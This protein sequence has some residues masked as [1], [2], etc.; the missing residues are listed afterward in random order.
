MIATGSDACTT[1]ETE[2]LLLRPR[3]LADTND[4]LLMDR[5]PEVT[6]YVSGPWSDA[7]A[8]REFIENRTSSPWLPGMGYWTIMLRQEPAVFVGWVLLIPV[9]AVGPE[10]EIGWRL[11]QRFWG[12]GLATEAAR[13]VL[14][15]AFDVL[16]LP[17][18]IAEIDPDNLGS[19]R[20]AEKIGLKQRGA[21]RH[22]GKLAMRYSLMI[23]EAATALGL[24]SA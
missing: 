19:L 23:S 17:E 8:H 11:R 2:R 16:K 20:V 10:I 7:S 4:C 14:T 22:S 24:S 6:R 5:E 15:H 21:V 13:P 12:Q 1:F 3:T 9:D 18:V